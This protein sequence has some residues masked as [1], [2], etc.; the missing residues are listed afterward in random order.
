MLSRLMEKSNHILG[1][2]L[3]LQSSTMVHIFNIM[4]LS[5]ILDPQKL[6]HRK[7]LQ[8]KTY[9]K[10]EELYWVPYK[11]DQTESSA[12]YLSSQCF[13]KIINKSLTCDLLVLL[14]LISGQCYFDL[15]E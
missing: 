1:L 12:E 4:S 2:V 13:H 6:L 14:P 8:D 15:L 10:I 3:E 9:S 5:H 7:D 11:V